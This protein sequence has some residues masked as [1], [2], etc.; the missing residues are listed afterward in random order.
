MTDNIIEKYKNSNLQLNIDWE[1]VKTNNSGFR[2]S[3]EF[4]SK[5]EKQK[6]INKN[7]GS[8][9]YKHRVEELYGVYVYEGSFILAALESGFDLEL[10]NEN[11]SIYANIKEKS[12]KD[13][14]EAKKGGYKVK[15]NDCLFC[16]N[17]QTKQVGVMRHPANLI[18]WKES[19]YTCSV[20][21]SYSYF[22]VMP[23][24]E[25]INAIMAEALWL[26]KKNAVNPSQAVDALLGIKEIKETILNDQFNPFK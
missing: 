20:G 12:W 15:I 9:G 2:A 21:A 7:H 25:Q 16:W 18:E 5:C 26:I 13:M 3:M 23:K 8:Y 1:F 10:F 6:T 4:L 17:E 24:K 19:G 22:R 11:G 14:I